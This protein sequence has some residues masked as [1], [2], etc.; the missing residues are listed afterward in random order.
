MNLIVHIQCWVEWLPSYSSPCHHHCH[1][2][3]ETKEPDF[4]QAVHCHTDSKGSLAKP[5]KNK[6]ILKIGDSKAEFL[7]GTCSGTWPATQ[8]CALTRN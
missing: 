1:H 7:V 2:V 6:Q 3:R 5:G 8:A 4:N